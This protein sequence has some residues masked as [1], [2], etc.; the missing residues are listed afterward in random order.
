MEEGARAGAQEYLGTRKEDISAVAENWFGES[1]SEDTRGQLLKGWCV[2]KQVA[3]FEEHGT[4][5]GDPSA[6]GHRREPGGERTAGGQLHQEGT[7]TQ[8]EGCLQP[9]ER[10]GPHGAAVRS[11]GL[12]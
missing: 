7:R 2:K 4:V 10:G 5:W 8:G 6:G 3:V 11:G 1:R 9:R 12:S